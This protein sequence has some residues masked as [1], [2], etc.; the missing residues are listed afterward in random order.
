M[1]ELYDE[2]TIKQNEA[3]CA[4]IEENIK[5]IHQALHKLLEKYKDKLSVSL[6]FYGNG[7]SRFIARHYGSDE[8]YTTEMGFAWDYDDGTSEF[9]ISSK[10]TFRGIEDTVTHHEFKT[11]ENARVRIPVVEKFL[12]V[13]AERAG[14][15]T[16]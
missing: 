5:V 1:I 14:L 12:E 9:V 2:E 13:E 3:R 11:L 15:G 16:E 7:G 10:L 4:K 6:E 8:K